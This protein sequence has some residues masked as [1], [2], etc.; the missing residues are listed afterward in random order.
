M[1]ENNT[2]NSLI[3]GMMYSG[4]YPRYARMRISSRFLRIRAYPVICLCADSA[5]NG[6]APCDTA[7]SY[8]ATAASAI[9]SCAPWKT[10]SNI[11][12]AAEVIYILRKPSSVLLK[13]ERCGK[14][15]GKA[16]TGG[17]RGPIVVW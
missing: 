6:D 7:F 8:A 17:A 11:S 9:R 15:Y 16:R 1:A 2:L 10:C 12:S 13:M 5:A 14:A 3:N 4:W